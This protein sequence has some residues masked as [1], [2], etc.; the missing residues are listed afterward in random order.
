MALAGPLRKVASKPMARFGGVATI[1]CVTPGIYN[2][3]T[4]T[5]SETTADTSVRGVLE[6]NAAAGRWQPTDRLSLLEARV[7]AL[8]TAP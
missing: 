2:P 5:T 4:G 7:T 8:E 3:E 6:W 1:R